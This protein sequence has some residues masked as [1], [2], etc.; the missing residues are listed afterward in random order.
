LPQ[1]PEVSS[2][3]SFTSVIVIEA[4]VVYDPALVDPPGCV[5]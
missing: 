2:I 4:P 3:P 1:R 5:L